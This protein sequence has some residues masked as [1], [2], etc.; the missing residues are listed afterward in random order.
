[1]MEEEAAVEKNSV[2][3]KPGYYGADTENLLE[4]VVK[5]RLN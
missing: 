2:E 3:E 4:C 5:G 1:M